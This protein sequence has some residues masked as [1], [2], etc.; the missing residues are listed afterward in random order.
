MNCNPARSEGFAAQCKMQIPRAVPSILWRILALVVA[1]ALP[2]TSAR[3]AHAQ[4]ETVLYDFTGSPD[5][6]HPTSRLASDGAGNFYGTT[7]SGGVWGSGSLFELSPNGIGGWKES[8]IYSFCSQGGVNC[9]D[10]ANPAYSY[11]LLDGNGN[12]YGTTYNGG[13]YGFGAIFELSPLGETWNEQVLYSFA[14]GINGGNPV[15]GLVADLMGNLHGIASSGGANG[16]GAAFELSPSGSDWAERVTYSFLSKEGCSSEPAGLTVDSAGNIFGI[17]CETIFELLPNGDG[18]WNSTAVY[19]F[20]GYSKDGVDPSGTLAIDDTGNLYGTTEV[21]GANN[22][23]TV[24]KLIHGK[25]GWKEK[26]L[27]SFKGSAKD[28]N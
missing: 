23:G 21:G 16:F 20:P 1:F 6:A 18:G 17:G 3:Q 19:T 12:L 2:L 8:V 11:V 9:T 15:N 22:L 25:D 24:Y 10:G 13:K 26:R 14:G 28:G 7:D 4:A 27:Y 5:G